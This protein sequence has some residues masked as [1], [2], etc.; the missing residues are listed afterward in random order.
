MV[1]GVNN[2]WEASMFWVPR[3][4]DLMKNCK[5][6]GYMNVSLTLCFGKHGWSV[7]LHI[8]ESTF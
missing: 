2:A 1:H 8:N 7:Q 4:S 6:N 5:S 3:F